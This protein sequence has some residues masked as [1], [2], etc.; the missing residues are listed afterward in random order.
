[1]EIRKAIAAFL[2]HRRGRRRSPETIEQYRY[3]LEDLWLAWRTKQN[4]AHDLAQ[5]TVE[6]LVS[7]FR[8]LQHEHVNRRNGNIG[9]APETLDSAWRVLRTFW[10]FCI[11]RRWLSEEQASYFQ[12]DELIPRPAVDER[13]R[14]SMDDE[15]LSALISECDQISDPEE[16]ARNRALLSLLAETGMRVSEVASIQI[17]HV[18]LRERCAK[19]IG[20]GNREEWVFW[21]WGGAVALR[22]YLRVRKG[23]DTGALFLGT[24]ARNEGLPLT[25]DTIRGIVKRLAARAGVELPKGA[26]CHSI[27][28]RFAHKGIDSGLDI[29]QVRQLMRHRHDATTGRYLLENKGRLAHIHEK[30]RNL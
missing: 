1:M 21:S 20:K 10:N 7:Y 16:R 2:D 30:I 25:G 15:T 12:D 26:P 11:R 28:H 29:S 23:P 24:S 14:P 27:R 13:I 17:E 5:I 8:Y 22:G 3:Q 9:L 6:E 4:L 19:V 18:R